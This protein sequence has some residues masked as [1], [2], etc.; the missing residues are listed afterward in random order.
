LVGTVSERLADYRSSLAA[1]MT[2]NAKDFSSG[3]R[4]L[5]STD[6]YWAKGATG[7]ISEPPPQVTAIGGPWNG[8]TRQETTALGPRTVYWVWFDEPQLDEYGLGPFRGGAIDAMALN[9][10]IGN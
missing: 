1:S 9:L 5:V 3:A 7:T 10:L 8:L 6:Y 2:E 4:V